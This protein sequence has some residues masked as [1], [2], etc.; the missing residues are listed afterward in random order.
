M[1]AAKF[2]ESCEVFGCHWRSL[3]RLAEALFLCEYWSPLRRA[4]LAREVHTPKAHGDMDCLHPKVID[5]SED[6]G[7]EFL[8]VL[9]FSEDSTKELDPMFTHPLTFAQRAPGTRQ[10]GMLAICLLALCTL[11]LTANAQNATFTTFDPPG[12]IGTAP[13]SINSAGV[14]TGDYSDGS[15]SR[16]FV[17][18][19]DGTFTTFDVPGATLT[20]PL[21]INPAGVI[22]GTYLDA[23]S[24]AHGFLRA[25]DGTIKTLYGPGSTETYPAAINQAGT[26]TGYY[27]DA[28]STHG[29]LRARDGT[30][31]TS[32]VPGALFTIPMGINPAGVISGFYYDASGVGHGFLRSRHGTFKS[33]D[34]PGAIS[35]TPLPAGAA[36][37]TPVGIN[38]AG[39]ITG[40]YSDSGPNYSLH[41]F[42]RSY[43]GTFTIIDAPGSSGVTKALGINPAR[44]IMGIYYDD[45]GAQHAFV[46]SRAG[47]YTTFDPPGSYT[48]PTS[49]NPAGAITGNYNGHGF[50]RSPDDNERRSQQRAEDQQQDVR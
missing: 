30:F 13:T 42:L 11:G 21:C 33:F 29:F 40:Y 27:Y 17:R 7:T 37:T 20:N 5:E 19:S 22:T 49:I 48:Y 31:T 39:E 50:L 44:T 12:A 4:V 45:N 9:S 10:K 6:E 14:I 26:I 25:R 1:G 28:S 24:V 43:G 41:G 35:I 2:S 18:S 36:Y 15:R 16:G 46:R 32:D 34:V 8:L 3:R 47:T 38:P 23:S